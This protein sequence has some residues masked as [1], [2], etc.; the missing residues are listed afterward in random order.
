M[1]EISVEGHVLAFLGNV[2]SVVKSNKVAPVR[3]G[4]NKASTF[5]GF[6]SHHDKMLFSPIEDFPF[7][8]NKQHCFLVAF[9][10]VSRELYVKND[11]SKVYQDLKGFD[12]GRALM[13]QFMLQRVANEIISAN[14]LSK[15][16]LIYI[17]EKLDDMLVGGSYSELKHV[18]FELTSPPHIMGSSIVAPRYGFDGRPVQFI[19]QNKDGIPDYV[20]IN[21]FSDAG[22]GYIVFSWLPEHATTGLKL[23]GQFKGGNLTSDNLAVFMVQSLE[24]IYLHPAWWDSLGSSMQEYICNI[25]AEGVTCEMA[26]S[27]LVNVRALSMPS[28]VR[29]DTSLML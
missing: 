23:L 8:I 12:K 15:S 26:A 21:S 22:K 24:N 16:D 29:I 20:I 7:H 11:V 25:F 17:K 13:Q 5:S 28:I 10:A 6:C 2:Q 9:R 27:S 19:S 1:K 18:V 4:V 14:D 3:V